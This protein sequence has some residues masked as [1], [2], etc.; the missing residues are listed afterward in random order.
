MDLVEQR[1]LDIVENGMQF[2][3]ERM[4]YL[5]ERTN[6]PEQEIQVIHIGGTNG[7]GSTL[8]FLQQ[9]LTQHGY[10]VG[11]FSS[12][13]IVCFYEQI[14]INEDMISEIELNQLFQSIFPIIME[15]KKMSMGAPTL[16]EITTI[17]ALLYFARVRKTDY[18]IFEVGL[19][20]KTDATNI[21]Q[22]IL[23]LLTPISLEHTQYLGTTLSAIA[24]EKGGILKKDIPLITNIQHE[25]A[26]KELQKIADE[27]E[28]EMIQTP[29]CASVKMDAG[30]GELIFT[31]ALD[32]PL[33]GPFR[34]QM[35]GAH[36]AQN[37][38][39]ALYTLN[40]LTRQSQ[41]RLSKEK[42]AQGLYQAFWPG[43]LEK[44][45]YPCEMLLDGSHNVDGIEKLRDALQLH[46]PKRKIILL[47]SASADKDHDEI[48]DRLQQITDRIHITT[49]QFY[50]SMQENMAKELAEKNALIYQADWQSWLFNLK[51]SADELVVITGSL[52][53]I[54]EIRKVLSSGKEGE[55]E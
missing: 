33:S 44:R 52:Y 50:R 10:T 43:R 15:M 22:P 30:T 42:I 29:S 1:I 12:P 8:H 34:L 38:T 46:F 36:Q 45:D 28:V 41:I 48:I 3:L 47:F 27:L 49:F 32:E 13:S 2:G 5:L 18:C 53:F 16:F 4:H 51:V 39:L 24:K 25:E 20:G 23:T 9:V 31:T 6:H 37:A 26:L 55:Q 54:S 21:V 7:K 14:K 19:G 17:L 11:T 35:L 40:Q